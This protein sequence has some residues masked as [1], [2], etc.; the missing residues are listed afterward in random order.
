MMKSGQIPETL[1]DFLLPDEDIIAWTAQNRLKH[2]ISPIVIA[3][4]NQRVVAW[5]PTFGGMKHEVTGT[6]YREIQNAEYKK[7]FIM[8]SM[9]LYFDNDA[10][11]EIPE[12][13][14]KEG[15]ALAKTIS[16]K[17]R[18]SLRGEGDAVGKVLTTRADVN[19]QGA[20]AAP[21]AVDPLTAAKT[22]LAAGEITV[23]EFKEI[24]E[25]LS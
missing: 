23:A 22:R 19:V 15:A 13:D 1:L 17:I 25:L 3:A 16:Q 11:L 4:T 20:L 24:S 8:G 7:G 21:A 10:V 2:P 5:I 14:N 18:E 6:D 12:M 9:T